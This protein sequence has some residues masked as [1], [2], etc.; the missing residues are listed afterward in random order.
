[1]FFILAVRVAGIS[2]INRRNGI[3]RTNQ[4]QVVGLAGLP[5]LRGM[6]AGAKLNVAMKRPTKLRLGRGAC[7]RT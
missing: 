1:M 5:M 7:E 6:A 4:Y 2:D 3:N